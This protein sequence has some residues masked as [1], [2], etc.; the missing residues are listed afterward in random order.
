MAGEK[1]NDRE[2]RIKKRDKDI[3]A[4][5]GGTG[6]EGVPGSALGPAR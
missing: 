2:R 3:H 4:Q 6:A 1:R 5:S